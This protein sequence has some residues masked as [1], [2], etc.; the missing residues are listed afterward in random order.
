[1]D[2]NGFFVR[3]KQNPLPVVVD[4]WASWCG[5]CRAIEPITSSLK[6]EY[7]GRVDFWKV[8]ADEQPDL[9]R[10]LRIYGIPTLVAF[11]DGEEVARRTGAASREAL[12]QLFEAALTGDQPVRSDR[13]GP[14]RLLRL[15]AGA[16]MLVLAVQGGFSGYYL[17]LAGLGIVV[18]FSAVYDRCPVYKAVSARLSAWLRREP[19][20]P[21]RN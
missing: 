11:Q 15:G 5:P 6:N 1:M 7:T 10:S 4:F 12:S 21:S 3:L 13:T 14:S 18:A 9:L 16:A 2:E 8:N 19:A 20:S 17:L